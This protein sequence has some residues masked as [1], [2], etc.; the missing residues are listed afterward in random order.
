MAGDRSQNWYVKASF[1]A[2]WGPM[3]VET[4]L[5]MADSGSFARDDLARCGLDE[6]WQP[7]PSVLDQL[8][9][10][11]SSIEDQDQD[12][13]ATDS[14]PEDAEELPPDDAAEV[15]SSADRKSV[16]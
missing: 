3:S 5:E 15:A 13:G 14:P 1:G 4:L 10:S 2:E 11:T 16:V 8:R 6:E 9:A 7:V 12:N